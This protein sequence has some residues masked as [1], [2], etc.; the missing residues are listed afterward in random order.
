MKKRP[1]EYFTAD[2]LVA[3]LAEKIA[4]STQKDVAQ[5]LGISQ[6]YVN[7]VLKRRRPPGPSVSKKL[8]YERVP[9]LYRRLK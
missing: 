5:E 8:G 6:Q 3:Q 1:A 9:N 4:K 2:V 7:D